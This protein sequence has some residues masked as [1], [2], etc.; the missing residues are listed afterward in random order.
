M[1][2][3]YS[4]IVVCHK[5]KTR[6]LNFKYVEEIELFIEYLKS[7]CP[8]LEMH[9][10]NHKVPAPRP[11]TERRSGRLWCPWCGCWRKFVKWGNYRKCEV[12]YV[13]SEDYNTKRQNNLI[14]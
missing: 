12:C 8:F 13:S 9:L 14:T 1:A 7:T 6:F 2:L 3:P 5:R 4:V 11:K 10:V